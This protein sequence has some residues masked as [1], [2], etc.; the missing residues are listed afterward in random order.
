MTSDTA[1][2]P[3]SP[4]TYRP[5]LIPSSIP[6][7]MFHC[8]ACGEMVLAGLPHPGPDI[9]DNDTYIDPGAP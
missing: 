3:D 2:K 4:C 5:E 9:D 6:L 1:S 7:G 8:P